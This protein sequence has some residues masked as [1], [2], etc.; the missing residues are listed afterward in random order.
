MVAIL[1]DYLTYYIL[2]GP[3]ATYRERCRDKCT[4]ISVRVILGSIQTEHNG[5]TPEHGNVSCVASKNSKENACEATNDQ[6]LSS[7][8]IRVHLRN[9]WKGNT[10]CS[11]RGC[12]EMVLLHRKNRMG[13][14]KGKKTIVTG[15]S[16][17]QS[18]LTP[19][20]FPTLPS[21][22]SVAKDKTGVPWYCPVLVSFLL[23]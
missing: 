17:T 9:A 19:F 7:D 10:G 15:V 8:D 13:R 21:D 3:R 16:L 11:L 22:F 1:S 4:F 23:L 2:I 5:L 20:M 12:M 6:R 18:Q 14:R